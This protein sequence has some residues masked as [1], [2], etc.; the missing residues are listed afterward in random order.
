M[1]ACH[2]VLTV[3]SVVN[4]LTHARVHVHNCVRIGWERGGAKGCS[5]GSGSLVGSE[6]HCVHHKQDTSSFVQEAAE[7]A[8][9]PWMA[10]DVHQL[11]HLAAALHY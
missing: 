4:I 10:R 7:L 3:N 5:L 6:V 2:V 9:H 8:P 11:H 1:N